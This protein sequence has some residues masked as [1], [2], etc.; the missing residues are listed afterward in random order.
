MCESNSP[1]RPAFSTIRISYYFHFHSFFGE[2]GAGNTVFPLLAKN[3]NPDLVVHA[4][5]YA[6]SAVELVKV[7]PI[8]PLLAMLGRRQREGL[9]LICRNG[10][11]NSMYPV[12]EHGKG[13]LHSSVWDVTS[14]PVDVNVNVDTD[15]S[16]GEQT[17]SSSSSSSLPEGVEPGTVDIA[18]MIFVMSAL[19]PLEWQRA[20]ANAY[21]VRRC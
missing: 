17:S 11:A 16:S 13:V 6:P 2:Q 14:P 19:H 21:K 5:D 4:C 12:P 10:Q 1:L 20:V 9:I 7:R 3:E 8:L 18:V 15:A